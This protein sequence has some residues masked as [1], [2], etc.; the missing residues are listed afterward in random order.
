MKTNEIF[1]FKRFGKYFGSD[2]RT[3]WA[4]FG[5]SLLANALFLPIAIYVITSALHLA[6]RNDWSG[7]SMEVRLFVFVAAMFCIVATMPVK[8]YGKV[9]EKQY[10]SFW[11]TLPASRLEKF[12]SMVI[13]TCII[14]PVTSLVIS[15]GIDAIIC[16][17][18]HTCG[19]SLISEG[20]DMIR[21]LGTQKEITLNMMYES[22]EIHDA[23]VAQNFINQVSSP[24]L[25][26]DEI[27]GIT[28]PFLLGAIFFKKGKTVKTFLA[29]FALSTMISIIATPMMFNWSVEFFNAAEVSDSALLTTVFDNAFFRNL[30]LIDTI[31]DLI[32]NGALL[33]GIWFR[34]KTLKH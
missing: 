34:I 13:M 27:F 19:N 1:D 12:L 4:N 26:I 23:E 33:T 15:L 7:P 14:V 11:L 5:L 16:G 24:W 8:S 10:G 30:V 21:N 6:L 2:I 3:C 17:L 18:D 31:G 20:V 32:W 25:Y 28:L 9:T 22:L 29:I